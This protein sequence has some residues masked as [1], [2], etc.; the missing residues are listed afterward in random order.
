ML[1]KRW[2]RLTPRQRKERSVAATRQTRALNARLAGQ[3]DDI[4]YWDP[5]LYPLPEYAI[6]AIVLPTGKVLIFG[7]EPKQADG[8][9]PNLGSARLFDPLTGTV[10][11]VPPPPAAGEDAAPIFCAGQTVLSDGRVL[12]VGGNL[13]DPG[14]GRPHY[15]GL[16]HTF[17]FDP[18]SA[19]WAPGPRMTHGRWY[20]TLTR[21]SSGDIVIAGGLDEDGQGLRNGRLDILRPGEDLATPLLTPYPAGS[22]A[23]PGEIPGE[24]LAPDASVGLSLYPF[25]FTLPDGDVALAGPGQQDSAI[26]DTGPPL[27][28]R[29]AAPG[30]AWT[31]IGD[32]DQIPEGGPS[33]IH[34]GGTGAIEPAMK[35]FVGSWN[36][37]SMAGADDSGTGFH[38]A[39]KT[40]DRLVAGPGAPA[41]DAHASG[42][43]PARD[44]NRARFY[45]NNVLLPDGGI[46]VVGGGVGADYRAPGA[47]E[48]PV[49]AGN[50]YIGEPPP[51][52]GQS[53]EDPPVERKQ[54]ELRRPGEQTWRLGA[55]Q[56]EWRTYHSTAWLLPDARVVSAGDDGNM[57]RTADRD[58]AEI[59]WPPYL[60][61]GDACALRPVIRGV[62]APGPPSASGARQWATLTYGE[63]FGIF[64]EHAQ[65]GM[66]AVLVAPAAT[67]HGVDMNQRLVPLAV[68]SVLAGGG[69]NVTMPAAAAIAPPG[70]YMLFV[71]DKDGT[72]SE[73]RWVH[74]LASPEA[75]AERG[76]G[77]PA[78]ISGLWPSPVGRSCVNP[79]GSR[80]AE[81]DPAAATTTNAPTTTPPTTDPPTAGPAAPDPPALAAKLPAKLALL[82]AAIQR[83]NRRLDVLAPI[84]AL[85]SGS[86]A[87][88]LFS[89]G[90]HTRMTAPIDAR[91]RRIR[92]RRSIPAAQAALA[93]GILTIV[94]KGNDATFPQTVRLRA[95]ARK[96]ELVVRRPALSAGGRLRASGTISRRARGVVRVQLQ[97][98]DAAGRVRTLEFK[99]KIRRGTWRFDDQLTRSARDAIA[100]R[101]GTLHSY[102]LF[103]GYAGARMRGEMRSYQV[104]AAP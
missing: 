69:L 12:I 99:A 49:S 80:R 40:V 72:P 62:G 53:I 3:R 21:L 67:T 90:L 84:S 22:R 61:D 77:A 48:D 50:Y 59:Y 54:V 6:N 24:T 70:Y 29:N 37:L 91:R 32:I 28:D 13:A 94:Y 78:T 75:S 1:Q 98:G 2:Q 11:H 96:A 71:I 9:R 43:D 47:P 60:F 102:T 41:W 68:D 14:P 79:D 57:K 92:V 33:K 42:H 87:V 38:L 81:P 89:A 5:T 58:N 93:T 17:I 36:I 64:S 51:P 85:A 44:L 101:A 4:G 104:L 66:Q 31:Q 86:V 74:V 83:Q 65:P 10:V 63:R 26:L 100:A 30:S 15:S 55:A 18:W 19:R 73:A 35:A 46:V 95:A 16:D 23:D 20:P 39:R 56:Q 25:M 97:F 45:P 82:R 103:T 8:S 52:A 34:Q 7:R 27:F 88:D 76:A